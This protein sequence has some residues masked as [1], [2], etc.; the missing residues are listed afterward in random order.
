[1]IG[2]LNR[3]EQEIVK[4]VAL[5]YSNNWIAHQRHTNIGVIRVQLANAANKIEVPVDPNIERRV[6][7]ARW[8]WSQQ[9]GLDVRT[10][11]EKYNSI[12]R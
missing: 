8:E 5:G 6:L 4:F 1:M 7:I 9:L 3:A 10:L 11:K 2:K 12:G